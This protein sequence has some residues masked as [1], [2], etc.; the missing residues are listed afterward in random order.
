MVYAQNLILNEYRQQV[1]TLRNIFIFIF[2]VALLLMIAVFYIFRRLR[3]ERNQQKKEAN[4]YQKRL[5]Q[6]EN[7]IKG[8]KAGNNA[9]EEKIDQL[10]TYN[11]KFSQVLANQFFIL[12]SYLDDIKTYK[13]EIANLIASG[14]TVEARKVANN[15]VVKDKSIKLFYQLFDQNFLYVHPDFPNRLNALLRPECQLNSEKEGTLTPEQRIYA[16]I[17]LGID[18]SKQIVEILHY[19][20]QTIYN[21]RMKIRHGCIDP[22][23]KIDEVVATMY[24]QQ[25]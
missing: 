9:K 5:Q 18:E 1:H 2:I 4:K 8:E 15:T 7:T 17:S 14:K 25:S 22:N 6:L 19:S 12:S 20:V 24:R 21:Y 16:L 10:Q 13:K 3:T 23:I 11:Q